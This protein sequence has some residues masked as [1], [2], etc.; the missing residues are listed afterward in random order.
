MRRLLIALLFLAA[1]LSAAPPDLIVVL[2]IDQFPQEYIERFA[3]HFVPGGFRQLMTEGA[4]YPQAWYP[5][6]TT[7]TCPGHATIGTGRLPSEHGIIANE[8]F[9]DENDRTVYCVDDARARGTAGSAGAYSPVL[10][11]TDSLGD[12]LQ[13]RTPA[14]KVIGIG[15][16]DRS[17]ILMAGRKGDAAY[18]FDDDLPAFVSSSYYQFNP[19]VLDFNERLESFI[20]ANPRWEPLQDVAG[21][22]VRTDD[23]PELR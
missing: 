12:R 15:L 17:G 13:E 21:G 18:W 10:L 7:Y 1:P 23:P 20:A 14:S 19:R 6:A 16:K 5:F 11:G 22:A 4:Y 9:D 8:W 2:V 3:P